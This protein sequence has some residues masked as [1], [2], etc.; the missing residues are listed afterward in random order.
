MPGSVHVASLL[1]F[2]VFVHGSDEEGFCLPVL[3]A[4][5]CGLPLAVTRTG[6]SEEI[7]DDGVN[8]YFYDYGDAAALAGHLRLLAGDAESRL[9]MGRASLARVRERFVFEKTVARTESILAAA[10]AGG[11]L[12]S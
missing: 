2:D 11:P 7:V 3:E 9:R 4:A 10:A 1:Q 5:A 6:V 8:G 12:P